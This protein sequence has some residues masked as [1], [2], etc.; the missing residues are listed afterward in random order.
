MLS[1]Y[2]IIRYFPFRVKVTEA[3]LVCSYVP[4][5]L[6]KFL[7]PRFVELKLTASSRTRLYLDIGPFPVFCSLLLLSALL[8][9]LNLSVLLP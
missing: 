4:T 1:M 6:L 7:N 8:L 3:F 2:S 9:N 5:K